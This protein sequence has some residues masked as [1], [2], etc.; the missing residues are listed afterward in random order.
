M[1]VCVCRDAAAVLYS[2]S[3][4]IKGQGWVWQPHGLPTEP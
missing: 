4:C 1:C 3:E 2:G